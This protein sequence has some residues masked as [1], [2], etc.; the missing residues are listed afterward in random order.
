M[1][2][3]SQGNERQASEPSTL[4]SAIEKAILAE[5]EAC[6]KAIEDMKMGE[7]LLAAGELTTGERRTVRALLPWL[8]HKLRSRND[9]PRA[10]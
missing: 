3:G 7:I 5:R 6:A 2:R 1:R 4:G 9:A 8:A 10:S